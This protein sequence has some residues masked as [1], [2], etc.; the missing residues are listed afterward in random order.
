[1]KKKSIFAPWLGVFETL[2]VEKG[3]AF[4]VEEHWKSLCRASRVLGLKPHFD[5][6]PSAAELPKET[7]RLRWIITP[8]ETRYLFS[9]ESGRLPS[10]Y[11][12]D[13]APQTLGSRNW[14][15]QYKTVSY[16]T[17]WQARKSVKADEAILV[18]ER[19][20]VVSGAMS[21]LF[22]VQDGTIYT[23]ARKTGCREG[24]VRAWV[25]KEFKVK[26]ASISWDE[27]RQAD[28]IFLTNSWI[29]IMPVGRCGKRKMGKGKIT[30]QVKRAYKEN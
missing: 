29:G 24:I 22:W 30:H 14:D 6:R 25:I 7:G 19:G 9:R 13:L 23:C 1:M 10:T 8:T 21:N 11:S 17:H 12:I 2:R 15:A 16:L 20:E 26:E 28:E 18:N 3:R 4:F 27:L 5:L